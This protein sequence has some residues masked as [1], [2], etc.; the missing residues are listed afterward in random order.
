MPDN[1]KLT[2]KADRRKVDLDDPAEVEVLHRK[3]PALSHRAIRSAIKNA[4][5][6]RKNIISWLK[7]HIPK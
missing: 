4:G 6:E 7:T 5:P 2:G 3:F 1:K